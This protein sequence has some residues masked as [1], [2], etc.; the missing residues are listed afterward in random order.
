M[1]NAPYQ[2][3]LTKG[4][5]ALGAILTLGV[6]VMMSVLLRPFTF[7]TDPIIAQL[8]ACFTAIPISATFWFAYNMFMLVLVDQR[9]RNKASK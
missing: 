6:F 7:S 3:L 4:H 5:I 9:K 1:E 2:K 8:Q